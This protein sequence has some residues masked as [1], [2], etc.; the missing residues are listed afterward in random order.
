MGRGVI[1]CIHGQGR[2]QLHRSAGEGSAAYKEGEGSSN[3]WLGEESA[4]KMGR[5]DISCID[6]Q[7]R[8]QLH[9]WAGEISV[10]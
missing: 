8:Y 9:R 7:G 4:A 6:G 3:R 10:A 2:Y 5:G 1:S